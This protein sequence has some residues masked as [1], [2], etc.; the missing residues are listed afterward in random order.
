[1]CGEF[2][3]ANVKQLKICMANC[4]MSTHE[5]CLKANM[6]RPTVNNVICGRSVRPATLGKIAKALEVDVREIM[7]VEQ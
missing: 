7:E 3:R 2:M 4:C 5:L 6:P 1:M